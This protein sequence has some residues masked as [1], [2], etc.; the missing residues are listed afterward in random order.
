MKILLAI[1]GIPFGI[2]AF[3]YGAFVLQKIWLW[4][5]AGFLGL[6]VLPFAV[7]V[8]IRY[9]ATAIRGIT[10]TDIILGTVH[11]DALKN[12]EPFGAFVLPFASFLF[13]TIVLFVA[14]VLK[15]F[16]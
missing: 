5:I 1:I 3:L 9:L 14:W 7:A 12:T 8:G 2:A 16:I 6:P 10:Q 15:L 11:K 4:Y 13:Y